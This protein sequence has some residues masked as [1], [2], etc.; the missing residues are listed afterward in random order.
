MIIKIITFLCCL[1]P[2]LHQIKKTNTNNDK[3]IVKERERERKRVQKNPVFCTKLPPRLA[4]PLTHIHKLTAVVLQKIMIGNYSLPS[5]R[6]TWLMGNRREETKGGGREEQREVCSPDKPWR[7]KGEVMGRGWGRAVRGGGE[8]Q[9]LKHRRTT[10]AIL[11]Q[12]SFFYI[13]D[14]QNITITLH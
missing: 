2:P 11:I 8:G 13:N 6:V 4:S 5:P 12:A 9:Q 7:Y 10:R 1:Y 3:T 14:D